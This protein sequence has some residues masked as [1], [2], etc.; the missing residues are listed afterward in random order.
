VTS[1]VDDPRAEN[2]DPGPTTSPAADVSAGRMVRSSALVA[3]GTAASRLTGLVRAGVIGAVF[4]AGSLADAY[5]LA[6]NTPN[7]VYELLLGG[8]LSATLVPIFVEQSKRDDPDGASAIVT[9]STV[10]LAA[11]SV[12]AVLAAPLVFR[13]YSWRLSAEEAAAQAELAVPFMRMFLPQMLFYGV[14]ALATALLNAKRRYFAPAASPVLNNVVVCAALLLAAAVAGGSLTF[15]E[16]R[17]SV[18]LQLL[19]GFGTTAG[20]VAMT[21]PLVPAVRRAGWRLRWNLDWRHPAVR[22]V[23]RLS[24]WT[25]GYVAANQVALSVLL[26]LAYDQPGQVSA[27]TYAFVFFQLPHGLIAVSFMTTFVPELAEAANDGNDVAFRSRLSLGIRLMSAL[28]LP[29]SVGY[30]LLSRPLVSV[31][32]QRGQFSAS[33]AELTAAVLAN[34]AVGLVGFSIYLFALRGFYALR[35]TRTPFW[36]NLAANVLKVVLAVALVGRYGVRGLAFAYAAAYTVGAVA[37]LFSLGHRIGGV[38]G[39]RLT[40]SLGRLALASAVMGVAV[41]AVTRLVDGSLA[42]VAVAVPVGGVVYLGALVLLRS[43]EV[44]GLRTRVLHR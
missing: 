18:G 21:L 9:V 44:A 24:G 25:V 35:D 20:I 6:N 43:D 12:V 34:F 41:W 33:D 3:V 37:A 19:I 16:V 40:G 38:D 29:A 42:E 28:I 17:E 5:L 10:L 30:V 27:Y 32:L 13:I 8:V 7:I 4:G 39:R 26:A 11:I 23:V 31:L 15:D 36:L 22:E 1:S 14:M 2:L